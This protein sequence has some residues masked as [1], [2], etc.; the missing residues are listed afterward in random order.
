M[1]ESLNETE[2]TLERT[3][4]ELLD[5]VESKI[6]AVDEKSIILR[7]GLAK[8]LTE[9]VFPLA[10]FAFKRYGDN[11][12]IHIRP[13]IGHQNY[14]AI[15]TDDSC[16]PTLK[17]YIEVTLSHEGEI[18]HLRH[19]YLQ[20]HGYVPVTG[21]IKKEGTKKTGLRVIPQIEAVLVDEA[22]KS[23]IKR[24][25]DAILRKEGKAYPL[26]TCLVVMFNDGHMTRRIIDNAA[27][28]KVIQG[29]IIGHNLCFDE[30][31][32]VGKF[33]YAFR[34]YELIHVGNKVTDVVVK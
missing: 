12:L 14:D 17:K 4:K 27:I 7:Q 21:T 2:I 1:T 10:V 16:S 15:L 3:P 6:E 34:Q 11:K 33:K 29:T 28:D 19:V 20:E 26:S 23:E 24:V 8:Q 9:E 32:I 22:A 5:W 25:V 13:V 18:E 31:C 30:I